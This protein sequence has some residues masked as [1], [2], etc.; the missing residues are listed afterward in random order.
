MVV[1]VPGLADAQA[2]AYGSAALLLI[3]VLGLSL[4]ATFMTVRLNR[5]LRGL[6]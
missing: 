5:R 4:S 3:I 2:V 6:T 1:G